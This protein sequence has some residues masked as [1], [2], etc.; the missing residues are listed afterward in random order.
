MPNRGKKTIKTEQK[1]IKLKR[2]K[3]QR[4]SIKPKTDSLKQQLYLSNYTQIDKGEN[5]KKKP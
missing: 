3:P 1:L 4:T 2:K 5:K